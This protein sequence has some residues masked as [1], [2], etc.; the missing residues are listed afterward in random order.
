M[1]KLE[2]KL[3]ED[4]YYVASAAEF[5]NAVILNVGDS[6]GIKFEQGEG[7]MLKITELLRG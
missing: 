6:V 4:K 2:I 5:E 1:L 3:D 7:Q